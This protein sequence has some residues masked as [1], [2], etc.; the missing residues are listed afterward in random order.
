MMGFYGNGMMGWGGLSLV[1]SLFVIV[2]L[3][4]LVLLGMW[5]WK[6]IQKK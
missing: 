1:H 2:I 3:I 6:Q 5:L 4:D